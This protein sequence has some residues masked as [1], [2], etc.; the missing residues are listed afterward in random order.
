[1]RRLDPQGGRLLLLGRLTMFAIAG[2]SSA[3]IARELGADG[4]GFLASGAAVSSLIAVFGAWGVD[5]QV[6]HRSTTVAAGTRK[7]ARLMGAT[8]V[9]G[10]AAAALWPGL[11]TIGRE[12]GV[13]LCMGT[14]SET[15]RI[16]WL[17]EA[18]RDLAFGR[19][20]LREWISTLIPVLASASAAI[21]YKTPISTAT[22]GTALSI[23]L[24]TT[25][26]TRSSA[27]GRSA[28]SKATSAPV[29]WPF[30]LSSALYTVYF[31]ID[32]AMLAAMA[33]SEQVGQ[34]R[35]AYI[36]VTAA[37]MVPV[38][39]NTEVMRARLLRTS[40]HDDFHQL[41]VRFG[42]L[43]IGA[44]A[45]VT[46][47]MH[48]AG[49]PAIRIVYG[50]DFSLGASLVALLAFA[51]PGHFFNSWVGNILVARG[52]VA[53]VATLQ[54]VLVVVNVIGNLFAIPAAGA[55]GAAS[56]TIAT[57]SVGAVVYAWIGRRSAM[58]RFP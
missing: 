44:A 52:H 54:A 45:V 41:V 40:G 28:V 19:R 58:S 55:R 35:V 26:V 12:C 20:A 50:G 24:T 46:L 15:I 7:L 31:Q 29:D 27:R 56:M 14:A 48:F 39:L 4:Y 23:A 49:P 13:V 33:A 8:A 47:L 11:T 5:Q 3:L 18:Q 51:M 53:R 42:K 36:A 10:C 9:A 6:L 37:V 38:L 22:A 43:T 2:A 1:M 57:E 34:Y 32:A 30:F 21:I 25:V 16:P 17:V